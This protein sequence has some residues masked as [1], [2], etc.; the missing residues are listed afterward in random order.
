MSARKIEGRLVIASHNPGKLWELRQLLGPHGV[1]AVSA[2]ELGL[3]E[4]EET[5]TTFR[6]N[7]LLKAR[8][9]ARGLGTSRLR[10]R[11]RALRR[12]AGRRARRLFGA[13]GRRKQGF[14]R[15]DRA[16]RARTQGARREAALR[17]AFHLRSRDRLARR[18]CGRV[19]GPRRR[20]ARLSKARRQGLWLRPDLPARRAGQDLRRDDVGGKTRPA[21]RR[22]D[23]AVASGAGVS[24][25]GAG[26]AGA[27]A[28]LAP[29]VPSLV[30][31][32]CLRCKTIAAALGWRDLSGAPC[33]KDSWSRRFA[34][35]SIRASASMCTGRSACRNARIAISTATCA[36]AMSTRIASSKPFARKSPIAP[37]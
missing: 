19:R 13:L 28:K 23:R 25:A 36:V 31:T 11:F 17:R 2:G 7:A 22:I 21:R 37:P 35:H 18:P 27:A 14:W 5:E 34:P 12:R 29:V 16:R 3:P 30:G 1:D 15:G 6:G 24:G 26:F 32:L 4:P 20:R 9:A 8:A 10:R 33:D